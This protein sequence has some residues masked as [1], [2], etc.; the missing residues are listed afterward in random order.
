MKILE[1]QF[2]KNY[3]SMDQTNIIHIEQPIK[4]N[5]FIQSSPNNDGLR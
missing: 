4:E 1:E 2:R 5:T 3:P